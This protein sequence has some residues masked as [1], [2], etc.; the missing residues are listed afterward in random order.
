MS[1]VTQSSTKK[2]KCVIDLVFTNIVGA[3]KVGASSAQNVAYN[4]FVE[5]RLSK[6]NVSK[7]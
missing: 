3:G 2:H 7:V 5:T 1:K 4:Q 6:S